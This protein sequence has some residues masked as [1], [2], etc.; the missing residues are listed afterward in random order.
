MTDTSAKGGANLYGALRFKPP[1]NV[2]RSFMDFCEWS[3]QQPPA[4]R[5]E[6][7][8][9][10]VV[11]PRGWDCDRYVQFI[12]QQSLTNP[13]DSLK[14]IYKSLTYGTAF[15][16]WI[17]NDLE[18]SLTWAYKDRDYVIQDIIVEQSG[19][20]ETTDIVMTPD[21]VVRYSHTDNPDET[22]V[23]VYDVKTVTV[24]K[25]KRRQSRLGYSIEPEYKRQLSFYAQSL[26][27]T[28]AAFIIG[29]IDDRPGKNRADNHRLFQLEHDFSGRRL[30]PWIRDRLDG[31]EQMT[32][33]GVIAEKTTKKSRCTACHFSAIC[34]KAD[35]MQR[36]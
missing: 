13:V 6:V 8:V 30:L 29:V 2:A 23:A 7:H 19:R 32:A 34:Q 5:G 14:F 21:I 3:A 9:S 16:Q 18:N 36:R 24:S 22:A 25:W 17:Y 28:H 35:A 26:D 10:D 11:S 12:L 20:D 27:A 31:L 33:Q 15:H 4:L 1:P